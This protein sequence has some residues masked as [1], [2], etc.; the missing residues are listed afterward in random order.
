MSSLRIT[1]VQA[2]LVWENKIENLS[3]FDSLL[4]NIKRGETDIIVLPEMFTTGFSMNPTAFAETMHDATLFWLKKKS[5]ELDAVI[6]GSF[7]CKENTQF[8]NR[9][10]WMYPDGS[11]KTYDKRHRFT[12]ARENESYTEGVERLIVEWRGWRICP[13]ICYD[14]RFPVWARNTL[15][16]EQPDYDI[17]IYVANWPVARSHHWRILSEARAIENQAFVVA[18]NRVGTD[19][20]GFE[21]RGDTSVIDYAGDILLRRSFTEGVDTTIV[22]KEKMDKYRK[23]FG[24]LAD[25][26]AFTINI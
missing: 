20:N 25:Q 5:W 2:D 6:T 15:T 10:V 18:V 24:F 16:Y 22:S 13:L 7:I 12:L 14:L 9:L 17:L 23:K 1:T 11:Y 3:R 8:Y 4:K 19:A 21:H 26:D